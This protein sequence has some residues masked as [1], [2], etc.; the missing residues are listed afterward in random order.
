MRVKI[1]NITKEDLLDYV[2]ESFSIREILLKMGYCGSGDSFKTLK[3]K[4]EEFNIDISHFNLSTKNKSKPNHIIFSENTVNNA[5]HRR[6]IIRDGLI[7]YICEVCNNDG[8]HMGKQLTL[9][10]DHKN[11]IKTDNRLDN[12]RFLCPNC[13]SQTPTFGTKN[14]TPKKEKEKIK[15]KRKTKIVWPTP[16]DLQLLLWEKPTS[17]IAIDLGVSDKSIEKFCK[18]HNLSKP[19]RGY[20][21]NL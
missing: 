4:L 18:K 1:S 11:G 15:T 9:Q 3:S 12:F 17:K 5:V 21:N 10:L 20:W 2:K 8:N 7:P 6:R 14:L 19:P 13:H 16:N